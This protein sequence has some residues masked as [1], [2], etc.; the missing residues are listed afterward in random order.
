MLIYVREVT[1]FPKDV[2]VPHSE[3]KEQ[4]AK[5]ESV[6]KKPKKK[7]DYSYRNSILNSFAAV[8]G[9]V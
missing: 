9:G 1:T 6:K 3:Q 4:V 5:E 2:N 8:V 7:N